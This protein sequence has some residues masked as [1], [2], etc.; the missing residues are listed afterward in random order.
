MNGKELE[1][2][3]SEITD[4][5]P[6]VLRR[7]FALDADDPATDLPVAQLR[8]CG[9]LRDGP[10]TMS[11][12]SRELGISLSATTQVADRLEKSGMVERLCETGDRRVRLLR[13]TSYGEGIVRRRRERR[14]AR[15][16][17]I[18]SGM[19]PRNRDAVV[20]ALHE[21][22]AAAS[23]MPGW[24]ESLPASSEAVLD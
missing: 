19:P 16:A 24:G 15:V 20:T 3:A 1:Q 23:T 2:Q 21:L 5:M 14:V 9:I 11:E 6:R 17:E 18:L 13:L 10:H 7:L 4:L 8:V 22:L 12:I